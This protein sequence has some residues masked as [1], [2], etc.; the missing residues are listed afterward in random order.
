MFYS[1]LSDLPA[2]GGWTQDY[3]RAVLSIPKKQSKN[4]AFKAAHRL[5][6]LFVVFLQCG[7]PLCNRLKVRHGVGRAC[8]IKPS[9]TESD[10]RRGHAEVLLNRFGYSSRRRS[11]FIFIAL[12]FNWVTFSLLLLSLHLVSF[13]LNLQRFPS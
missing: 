11:H 12:V 8:G 9:K 4:T 2:A 13:T 5:K 7:C 10:S 1:M 3:S 6:Q